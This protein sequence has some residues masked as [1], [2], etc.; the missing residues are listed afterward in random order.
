M[1]QEKQLTMDTQLLVNLPF[2]KFTCG[3]T[4]NH[5]PTRYRSCQNYRAH[6]F[7]NYKY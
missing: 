6:K 7:N 1:N 3:S 4:A 5:Q 2:K